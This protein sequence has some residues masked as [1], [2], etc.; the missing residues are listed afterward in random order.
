[1]FEKIDN[2]EDIHI[3]ESDEDNLGN[4]PE[5][6]SLDELAVDQGLT[7]DQIV[8]KLEENKKETEGIK[9][10]KVLIDYEPSN[11]EVDVERGKYDEYKTPVDGE[12]IDIAPVLTSSRKNIV[13]I[14]EMKGKEQMEKYWDVSNRKVDNSKRK[15][16]DILKESVRFDEAV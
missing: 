12:A 14:Q 13:Q 11:W 5:Y 4:N 15:E 1:M 10:N 6:V 16:K 3:K 9:Q 2:S 8:M 7:P